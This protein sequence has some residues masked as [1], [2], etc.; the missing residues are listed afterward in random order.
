MSELVSWWSLWLLSAVH[1]LMTDGT[2]FLKEAVDVRRSDL[3]G[4]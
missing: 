3:R 2:V 1:R 4:C